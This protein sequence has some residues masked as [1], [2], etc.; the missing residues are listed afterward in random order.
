MIGFALLLPALLAGDAGRGTASAPAAG[1][2]P[3]HDGRRLD[4]FW[5]RALQEVY[6]SP[7]ELAAQHAEELRRGTHYLKLMRG[8]P[9]VPAV[10]LT[11]DDGPH[12]E[13][14]P[15]ILAILQRYHVRA[16]FFVV[17][18]M[19]EQYPDLVRAERA[20]GHVI[21]NHTYH[22]V[23]LT[24]IPDD[25]IAPEWQ[26]CEDVVKAITGDTMRFCRPPGGDYDRV[27]ILAATDLGLTTVLWTDDPGDYA[28]PG[29][30]TIERRVL[31]AIGNGGIILLHDGV[32]Q[33]I[34]VLPQIIEG[35]R[36]RGLRFE[37]V[38]TMAAPRPLSAPN[39]TARLY[40]R[41]PA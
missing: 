14:T 29:E 4:K 33:T 31:G 32:Q 7:G 24:K 30:K 8:D 36:R 12:P 17:G 5:T 9:R 27:V 6:K 28:S 25:E 23:N 13:F 15:Q 39:R 11:F 26:A 37:T 18:K 38:D 35:L 40:L 34:G 22:H 1:P 2:G 16:T 41:S 10:T 21:G 3:Q 19:A 20:G